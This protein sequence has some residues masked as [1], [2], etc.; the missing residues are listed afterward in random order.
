M[1]KTR[2]KPLPKTI[3]GIPVITT[4]EPSTIKGEIWVSMQ[5]QD[6]SIKRAWEF[7]RTTGRILDMTDVI[8]E[9]DE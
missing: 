9:E 1:T 4:G 5:P 2:L 8:F 3:E 6:D 7:S